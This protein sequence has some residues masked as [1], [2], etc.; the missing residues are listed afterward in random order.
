M[1]KYFASEVALK[2]SL[3]EGIAVSVLEDNLGL[4]GD[5]KTGVSIVR[6]ASRVAATSALLRPTTAC[7]RTEAE[8]WPSAQ[9]RTSCRKSA[10]RSPSIAT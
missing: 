6:K 8:A 9:A 5:E 3:E 7:P 10:I 1:A 4:T 2:A